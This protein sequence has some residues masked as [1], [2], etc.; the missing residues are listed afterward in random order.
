MGSNPKI[1]KLRFEN[2]SFK[3]EGQDA[4]FENVDFDFPMNQLVWVKAEHGSGRSTLLQLLAAL[5]MPTR[6]NYFINEQNV[7]EMSFE[8]FLPYRLAIG[9]GFDMGG[10]IHNR[11]LFENLMLPLNYH[12]LLSPEE[13]TER[14]TKY[15]K[16]FGLWKYKDQRPS[17]ISGGSKKLACL[18]RAVIMHP[19]MVL[20]DDPTVGVPQETS[21]KFFDLL[22][23]LKKDG[24]LKHIFI[25]SFDDKFMGSIEHTE[26]F[27]E[28]GLLHVMAEMPEKKVVSL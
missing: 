14:V 4:I 16:D 21:L 26:I 24:E 27:I 13:A 18:I 3:P 2:L 1:E 8:E 23:K 15:L 9:Y 10:L 11:T 5:Q 20:L 19:Q 12:K 17:F 6:G 25:S 22:E 7:A 28:G